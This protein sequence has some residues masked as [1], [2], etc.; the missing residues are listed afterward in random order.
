M[1][2]LEK[3]LVITYYWPPTSG[4]GVQRW[5]K[6]AKYLPE[7]GVQPIIYTPENPSYPLRDEGLLEE[8]PKEVIV[9]K[10]DIRE[11]YGLLRSPSANKNKTVQSASNDSL[12]AKMKS[13]IRGNVFIPDPKVSWVKPSVK[14]LEEVI[15]EYQINKIIT[16]G[17]PHSMHLIGLELKRRYKLRWYA[18]F[19][20][21]WSQFGDLLDKYYVTRSNRKKYEKLESEVLSECDFVLTTS[22][23]MVDRLMP[24]HPAKIKVITNGYDEDDF[25]TYQDRS[26]PAELSIYH[27][28]ML[29][30]ERNAPNF[31]QA[32]DKLAEQHESLRLHL[33]GV[34][35][36]KVVEEIKHLPRLK[37]RLKFEAFKA[38]KEVLSDYEQANIL[39]LLVNNSANAN[40]CIPGKTFEYLATGKPIIC[41]APE[42]SEVAD[43]LY[44]EKNLLLSYSSSLEENLSALTR[45]FNN[46]SSEVFLDYKHLQYSRR[47][48]TKQLAEVLT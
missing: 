38:H 45:F 44:S 5:L 23:H 21:P 12:V 27:A 19:R 36:G 31:W 39:L 14:Y 25:S 16:T 48:L 32:L 7:F 24:V 29:Y 10:R 28:G 1:I 35:S 11:A 15:R 17:P 34:D 37:N 30:E 8:L 26:Q 2:D 33:V 18:D 22:K 46:L 40:A 13:W 4:S 20:D 9:I 41:I 42:G 43:A 3:V 47:N 6:F